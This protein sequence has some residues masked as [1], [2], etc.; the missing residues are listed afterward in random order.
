M[1]LN[2]TTANSGLF[3]RFGV[4][5]GACRDIVALKGGSATTN[6][7]ANASLGARGVLIEQ[8]AAASPTQYPLVDGI[9]TLINSARSSMSGATQSLSSMAQ[10]LFIDQV[11]QDSPLT[12]KDLTSALK[13]AIRQMRATSDSINGSTVSLGSQTA[14]GTATGDPIIVGTLKATSGYTLQTPFAESVKFVCTGD[15]ASGATARNETLSA[16]G[17]PAST[18]VFSD[19]YPAGSGGSASLT[20][21]DA[22]KNN[23]G[24]NKLQN[25]SFETFT[26]ADYPDNWVIATGTAGTQVTANGSGYTG[27]NAVKINGDSGGTLTLWHGSSQS[28]I[29]PSRR[30]T[31]DIRRSVIPSR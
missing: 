23:T 21:A 17:K 18:D 29:W 26:T 15:A 2:Y 1:A 30:E 3:V 13:E 7:G 14:F 28:R 27:A 4:L 6:V 25:S 9:W 31:R 20:L 12:S 10:S 11:N 22:K 5:A 8:N 24:G 19:A 16:N